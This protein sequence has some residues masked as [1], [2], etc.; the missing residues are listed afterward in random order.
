MD[1]SQQDAKTTKQIL[2]ACAIGFVICLPIAIGLHVK[3]KNME[4]EAARIKAQT[5]QNSDKGF[6]YYMVVVGAV[7]FDIIAGLCLLLGCFIFFV[8]R[9]Q[10]R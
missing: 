3:A 6:Q 7:F 10:S 2:I 4:D 1:T 9:K 8:A 5:G